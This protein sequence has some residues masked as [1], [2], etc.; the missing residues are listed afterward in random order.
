MQGRSGHRHGARADRAA[1]HDGRHLRARGRAAR[2][3]VEG[4]LLPLPAGRRRGRRAAVAAQLG[5]A[6]VTWAAVSLAD[7]LDSVV[8]MYV[9]GERPTGSRDPLGL[10]RQAQGAV[11][12]LADLPELTGLD[13]RVT[14]GRAAGAGG[15]AV[16][17]RRRGRGAAAT[18]SCRSAGV[19]A[20]A[21]RLRR[22]QRAGGDARG[23]G[24]AEPARGAAEARGAVADGGLGGAAGRGRAAASA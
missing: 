3:G 2:A 21:A 1:G 12:I 23:R 15:R 8:G 7:K 9:A 16:R 19:P 13:R 14:L 24:H 17:R 10:R 5:A 6:A 4:D 22:P 18:P 11:K 20:R